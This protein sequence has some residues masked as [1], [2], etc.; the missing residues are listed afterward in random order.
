[1]S[2]RPQLLLVLLRDKQTDANSFVEVT[3]I[4]CFYRPRSGTVLNRDIVSEETVGLK[5]HID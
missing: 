3:T 4:T 2:I 1:M 5:Y